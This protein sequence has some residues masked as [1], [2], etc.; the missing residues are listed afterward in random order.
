MPEKEE[1]NAQQPQQP[2]LLSH[3]PCPRSRRSEDCS[4]LSSQAEM[5]DC[6]LTWAPRRMSRKSRC[7]RLW[8]LSCSSLSCRAAF[9]SLMTWSGPGAQD[10][11]PPREGVASRA[12]CPTPPRPPGPISS[13]SPSTPSPWPGPH[14]AIMGAL[15][16]RGFRLRGQ[17]QEAWHP[18]TFFP[19]RAAVWK[20]RGGPRN[21]ELPH[22]VCV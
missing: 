19:A 16:G 2:L 3:E 6:A 13:P 7:L 18:H 1:D 21:R 11:P 9:R 22:T 5:G 15:R 17:N 14:P 12:G 8:I 20:G 10:V 4:G